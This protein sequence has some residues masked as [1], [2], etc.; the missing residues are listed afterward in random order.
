[1]RTIW[2]SKHLLILRENYPVMKTPKLAALLGKTI[3]ATKTRAKL[4]KLRKQKEIFCW[5]YQKI[6]YL[7]THYPHIKTSYIADQLSTTVRA[8][9]CKAAL[10]G[11][12]K[13]PEFLSSPE[14]GI[15]VKGHTKGIKTR[16][17]KGQT[18]ANKGIKMEEFYTPETVAK[19][20]A[21]SY[22]KGHLPHNTKYDGYISIRIN[23][24]GIPYAWI[25]VA[26][27]KFEMLQRH[28]WT[29][30]NGPI[31]EGM[32]V[33]FKNNDH[34]DFENL[35]LITRKENLERNRIS[36]YPPDLQQTIR[37]LNKLKKSIREY[38]N[39]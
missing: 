28:I 2:T 38:E 9:Y 10:L 22:R 18:P 24:Q 29:E 33:A 39:K 14:S 15:L 8:V 11:L 32:L 7:K 34:N 6:E 36:Q 13:T 21:N 26:E 20:K 35:E 3:T 27:D 12:K 17:Q 16:F 23:K 1:M 30:K 31:P 5:T 4:L 25:R 19:F 37:L